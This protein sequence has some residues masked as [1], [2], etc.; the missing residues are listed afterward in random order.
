MRLATAP[1][2]RFFSDLRGQG[3][4]TPAAHAV[5][6]FA[7]LYGLR[8][9]PLRLPAAVAGVLAVA[10]SMLLVRALFGWRAALM[11]GVI[12]A[13]SPAHVEASRQAG[14]ASVSMA[15]A[16]ALS[17]LLLRLLRGERL[18]W[19]TAFAGAVALYCGY[20]ALAVLGAA[21]LVGLWSVARGGPRRAA[22]LR[23]FVASA[24]ALAL[25]APWAVYD[26]PTEPGAQFI[27]PLSGLPLLREIAVVPLGASLPAAIRPEIA[28]LAAALLAITGAVLA[29]RQRPP[30]A[31]FAVALLVV[32]VAGIVA[33]SWRGPYLLSS[34][35]LLFLLPV[36]LGLAAVALERAVRLLPWPALWTPGCLA[37]AAVCAW[38]LERPALPA[39][40]ED[41][42]GAFAVLEQNLGRDDLVAAP[43][44]S[45]AA[46]VYG[47][48]LAR[49]MPARDR[50]TLAYS[51]LAHED[52]GWLI[53][54]LAARLNPEAQKLFSQLADLRFMVDLSPSSEPALYFLGAKRR[55]TFILACHFDLPAQVLARQAIIRDCLRELGAAEGPLRQVRVLVG[56]PDVRLRNPTLLESVTLLTHLGKVEEA[57]ALAEAIARREPEWPEAQA[58]LAA[59]PPQAPPA[60][61]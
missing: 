7:S 47:L 9:T 46:R 59:I 37:I 51:W 42:R 53:A 11:S 24:I 33:T 36:L 22:A 10:A 56:D 23:V 55:Q 16:L 15:A 41:W 17:W 1:A 50:V 28:G 4:A 25:F 40:P 38:T 8:E 14:A 32:G 27:A 44:A 43:L 2:N 30:A 49:R 6:R 21:A 52:H 5:L 34:T 60:A 61:P 39:P 45:D 20:A 18:L 31:I 26:L 29:W 54:G 57:R 35:Q 12:L 19:R 3:G 58:A 48:E 13:A